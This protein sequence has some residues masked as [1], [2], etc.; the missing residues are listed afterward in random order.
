[1]ETIKQALFTGWNFM[2]W[3]RV[4]FGIFFGVQA[5]QTHDTFVGIVSAFFLL[6]AITNTGCCGN[7]SCTVRNV[8][9]KSVKTEEPEFE[10]VR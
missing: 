10:E 9:K 8:Q 7:R 5:F 4:A 6:T 2:R 3:L 1:M